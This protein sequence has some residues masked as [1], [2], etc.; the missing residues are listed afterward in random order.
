MYMTKVRR[1]DLV[2]RSALPDR[3]FFACGACHIL[4]YAALTTFPDRDLRVIWIK[5]DP[6]YTGNHIVAVG[7]NSALDYHGL[8]DWTKLLAHTRRKAITAAIKETA[9]PV[10]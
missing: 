1:G 10:A 3:V 4:A 2:R 6:G 5:P 7:G 9:A 8:S